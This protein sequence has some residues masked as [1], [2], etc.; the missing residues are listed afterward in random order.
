MTPIHMRHGDAT[1]EVIGLVISLHVVGMYAFSPVTGWAVD[2][3]GARSVIGAGSLLLLT[4][5]LPG[6]IL[7]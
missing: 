4:A 3:W 1:L 2:R 7:P 6:G 5:S